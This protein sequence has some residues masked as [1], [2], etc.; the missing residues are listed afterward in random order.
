MNQ[1]LKKIRPLIIRGLIFHSKKYGSRH[2]MSASFCGK[3]KKKVFNCMDEWGG[4]LQW[5]KIKLHGSHKIHSKNAKSKLG[6][7]RDSFWIDLEVIF[8]FNVLVISTV[9]LMSIVL[10]LPLEKRLGEGCKVW[11]PRQPVMFVPKLQLCQAEPH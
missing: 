2:V 3:K 7:N 10:L 11:V 6:N 8:F 4:W 9:F 5:R 1:F